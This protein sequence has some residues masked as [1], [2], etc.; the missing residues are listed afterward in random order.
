VIRRLTAEYDYQLKFVVDQPED[1]REVE[2]YLAEFPEIP[3]GR[4]MLMPQG[5]ET[6]ALAEKAAWL[7]PYCTQRG[8]QFSPRRQIE[9]FGA[10]RGT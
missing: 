6:E 1:C 10:Q 5:T 9:W 4:V 3:P 8:L 7:E 2:A